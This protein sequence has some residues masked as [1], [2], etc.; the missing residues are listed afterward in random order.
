MKLKI[1]WV[2]LLVLVSSVFTLG[3]SNQRR[4]TPHFEYK[5]FQINST[6]PQIDAVKLTQIG[7]EGWELIS[8][9]PVTGAGTTTQ[10]AYYFKREKR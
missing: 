5:L 4:V 6:D 7:A 3:W 2:V 10:L 8:V 9:V 1:F